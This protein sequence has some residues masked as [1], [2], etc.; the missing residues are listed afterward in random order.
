MSKVSISSLCRKIK[1]KPVWSF[2]LADW[3]ETDSQWQVRSTYAL[4]C[5]ITLMRDSSLLVH[6]PLVLSDSQPVTELM[7]L[8]RFCSINRWTAGFCVVLSDTFNQTAAGSWA[9]QK[10]LRGN[11]FQ[12]SSLWMFTLTW[13]ESFNIVQTK[14]QCKENELPLIVQLQRLYCGCYISNASL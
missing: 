2:R 12:R 5:T 3:C 7:S 4:F 6:F 13:R 8:R 1:K 9:A 11:A 14:T 10:P